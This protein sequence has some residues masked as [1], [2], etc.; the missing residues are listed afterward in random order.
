MWYY[1]SMPTILDGRPIKEERRETLKTAVASLGF[2]PTLAIIQVGKREDSTAYITQ[3]KTFGKEIGVNVEHDLFPEN[4]DQ[5]DIVAKIKEYNENKNIHGIIVQMPLPIHIDRGFVVDAIDPKKDVDGLT[6]P[7]LKYLFEGREGGFMPAT[8]RGII[9]L[10]EYYDISLE[11]KKVTIVGRSSLVGKPTLLALLNENATVTVCHS[12]TQ[13][14]KDHTQSAD[15]LIVA[16]GKPKFITHEYVSAKQVVVD[17][18]INMVEGK[19]VGDVDFDAVA[20]IVGAISPVPGGAGQMTVVSLY[21][22][23]LKAAML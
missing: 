16:I 17:V 5:D 10:L 4:A 15:I 18:G 20:D 1:Y 2:I 14:L 12:Q 23:L 9:S 7:N 8:S 11:G 21:E 13:N 3:K 6:A 19:M 22:N